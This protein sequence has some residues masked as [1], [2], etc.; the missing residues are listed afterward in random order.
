M[1][2]KEE[3]DRLIITGGNNNILC[4]HPLSL[5][6]G[7]KVVDRSHQRDRHVGLETLIAEICQ[8]SAQSSGG[9][10]AFIAMIRKDKPRYMRDQLLLLRQTIRNAGEQAVTEALRI[11]LEQGINSANDFK[12]LVSRQ[13]SLAPVTAS[14]PVMNPLNGS[15]PHQALLQP[16]ISSIDDYKYFFTKPNIPPYEPATTD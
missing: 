2:V 11:C 16:Q 1:G 15:L 13:E 7:K 9:L 8:S 14:Y 12:T 6:R 3:G 4:T 10:S 5:E